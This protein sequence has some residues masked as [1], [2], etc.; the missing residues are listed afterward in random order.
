MEF[1]FLLMV[2]HMNTVAKQVIY[3]Q[4]NTYSVGV[5]SII[6]SATSLREQVPLIIEGL[7]QSLAEL[8]RGNMEEYGLYIGLEDQVMSISSVLSGNL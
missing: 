8:Q 1:F 2:M 6:S 5:H 3:T 4:R 7:V